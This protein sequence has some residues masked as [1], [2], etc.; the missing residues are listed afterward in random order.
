MRPRSA[1]VFW[2]AA[3][4]RDERS[5]AGKRP[6]RALGALLGMFALG[7][8]LSGCGS[9]GGVSPGLR[10]QHDPFAIA[11][12]SH[13]RVL[14]S[15][16]SAR[17]RYEL[18]S[19]GAIYS[20]TKVI[21]SSDH[22]ER[23]RVGTNEP[24]RTATVSVM[25]TEHGY[26]I[27]VEL[28][29][30]R[31]VL[32]LYDSFEVPTG[33]HF[34]GGGER[35]E[36]VDLAGQ[37]VPIAVNNRCSYAPVPFFASSAGW[38]LR[39]AS[40]NL[41]GLAFP[42]SGGGAGCTSSSDPPCVFPPLAGR[43]EVCVR[44][45]VLDED[46]YVGSLSRVLADYEAETGRPSVPPPS[47]LEL[48]KWR[49]GKTSPAQVV[50]QVTRLQQA[51]IPV[52]WVELD[53]PWEPCIG[54]LDF[55]RSRIPDPA[56]LI[57]KVHSLGVRF[58]L[59]ISPKANCSAGYPASGLLGPASDRVLNLRDP[60]VLAVFRT[61]L[62]RLFALGVNGIKADRGDEVDLGVSLTN[63]YPLLFA[64]AVL[65]VMPKGDAAIFRAAT[66]GSQ[67][68]LPGMWG[69][70]Q[71]ESWT[72]LQ[73][74]I[75]EGQTAAMSGFSTWGSD[76]GGFAPDAL[77]PELF[78]RW[79]QFG[80]VSPVMEVGGLG[81]N[82]TPWL[83]GAGAMNALRDAAVLH[84]ELYPYLYGLLERGQPVLRPLGYAFPQDARS[85]ASPLE[86]L[87]GPDL[88][89]APVTGPGTTPSVY[90]PPGA[91][92]DL[93]TGMPVSGGQPT[94]T[95]PTPLTQFPLYL[96]AGAVVP[97]DLRTT[98]GSWWE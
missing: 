31:D 17:L 81:P 9:G 39:I 18:A 12:V 8:L 45:D 35:T 32:E 76:V 34:L 30:S 75:V 40:E 41:A 98:T 71:E 77:T 85:W 72:G 25:P 63:E 28:H 70:D 3:S 89:V 79:A 84:Y 24:G 27:D 66:V 6:P 60:R 13:G 62:K 22:G 94:F 64:R 26:R 19:S 23:Y 74:A 69:G 33:V 16:S 46:L 37:V 38:G 87:V 15:E 80:A 59:W 56:G 53:D 95:R 42:G 47:E 91:W 49:D 55:N 21:S 73:N 67:Q 57:E 96:R 50:Q 52:G 86:S 36:S 43:V 90:L 54:V 78:D 97:F 20:L 82:E 2:P 92:I 7:A 44:G 83:L 1:A 61:R 4:G 51:G 29:P 11:I 10:I 58:M 14:V 93:Y 88:F 68:V 65:G 48:I 5:G